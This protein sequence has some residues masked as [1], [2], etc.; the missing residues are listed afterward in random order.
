[1][2]S[3][4]REIEEKGKRETGQ[5]HQGRYQEIGERVGRLEQEMEREMG[6]MEEVERR[7]DEE[8]VRREAGERE[9]MGGI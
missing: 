2:E 5:D 8:E 4:I 9:L 1:M 3:R 6:R 7:A